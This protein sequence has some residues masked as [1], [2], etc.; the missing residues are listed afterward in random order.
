MYAFLDCYHDQTTKPTRVV[1]LDTAADT[2]ETWVH[3]PS[4][5][6]DSADGRWSFTDASWTR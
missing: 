5:G 2:I 3:N 1:T 4:T 6:A